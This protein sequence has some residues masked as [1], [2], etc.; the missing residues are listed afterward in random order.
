M[1]TTDPGLVVMLLTAI[2]STGVHYAV[3]HREPDVA[4][5]AIDSDVDIIVDRPAS[6]VVGK[7]VDVIAGEDAKLVLVWPYDTHALTTFWLSRGCASGVQLDVL[8]DPDGRTSYALRTD[9]ALRHAERGDRWMRLKPE[10][11]GLYLL[12][13][14]WAKGDAARAAE[15]ACWI[16]DGTDRRKL[17]ALA[18]EVLAPRG[19]RAARFAIAGWRP[20]R[21]PRI[22]A[23][24]RSRVSRRIWRRLCLPI[25]VVVRLNGA[26]RDVVPAANHV[27][28]LLGAVLVRA[29]LTSGRSMVRRAVRIVKI[30]RPNILVC[31]A[32]VGS[33]V[34][35]EVGV[36]PS[37]ALDD[38]AEEVRGR[39][40]SLARWRLK[41]WGG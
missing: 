40:A 13:K 27:R 39:L 38:V 32:D 33:R 29:E 31:T 20:G 25:G 37:A 41:E 12:S 3:L 24:V 10:V 6:E 14:R 8:H 5:G 2:E 28:Q 26:A 34:Q 30:R 9:A 15:V 21:L 4:V 36:V 7:L 11:E 17:L 22:C 16:A 35:I 1:P 23:T 18:H 19:V